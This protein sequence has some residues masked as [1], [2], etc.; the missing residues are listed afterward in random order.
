M[1][2]IVILSLLLIGIRVF[3]FGD[4]GV[5]WNRGFFQLLFVIIVQLSFMSVQVLF[6]LFCFVVGVEIDEFDSNVEEFEDELVEFFIK[7][8]IIE[9]E[10]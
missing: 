5:E 9:V 4:M 7:E 10:E 6:F 3:I 1:R 2:R 8:E